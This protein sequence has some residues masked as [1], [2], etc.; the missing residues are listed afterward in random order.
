MLLPEKMCRILVVGSKDKLK[1]TTELLYSLE[2][3]HPIDYLEGDEG[4]VIGSPFEEASE[5]SERLLK[6]RAM[7]KDLEIDEATN[8]PKMP[9]SDVVKGLE[10]SVDGLQTQVAAVVETK[11]QLSSRN[12]ALEG[13]KVLLEPLTSIPL[14]LEL[15]SGYDNLTVFTGN[16]RSNPEAALNALGDIEVFRS[17]GGEFVAV[18]VAS[19]K[20]SEAQRIL[21]TN[22]F[23]ETALPQGKGSPADLIKRI[24]EEQANIAKQLDE[25]K[26]KLS[27]LKG[28]NLSLILASD[29]HLSIEV[30]KAEFPLRIATSK[31]AF[32]IDA[33]I[34]NKQ[35]EVVRSALHQ[36]LGESISFEIVEVKGRKEEH[37]EDTEHDHD[38]AEDT[39]PVKMTSRR[40]LARF[41]GFT[42]LISTPKYAE[43]DPTNVI[44]LTFPLFFGLMVGDVAYGLMFTVLGW[45]G[46]K[47]ARSDDWQ[48]ISTMLFFGGIWATFFGVFMFGEA[49]GLHFALRGSEMTWS[50]L[51]GIDFPHALNLGGVSIPLGVFSKLDDVNKLLLI[52]VWIGIFHLFLGFGLGMFNL[53]MRVGLKH[54]VMEKFGW[55]LILLGMALLLPVIIANIGNIMGTDFGSMA[56]LIP[57]VILLVGLAISLVGEGPLSIL[58]LPGLLSNILSYTRLTAIGTS[59][60][61][62][63]LAFNMIALQM[64]APAG[65]IGIVFG[66]LIFMV[67]HLTVFMLAIISAGIHGIRLHYV[68][69]FQKFYLGGGT[70]FNPL[71]IVRKHTSER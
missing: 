46:L 61:G 21:V 44:A 53:T 64:L 1:E 22:G 57:L 65:G 43:F 14:D 56:F 71:R 32:V 27:K 13:E 25:A 39:T 34:P 49:F 2:L 48:T 18:F 19:A 62:L 20:A 40:P 3:V 58:E 67:G 41:N 28:D 45:V 31:N 51:L 16:V 5:V 38:I 70:K 9:L 54:A 4:L 12:A 68:E 66:I 11:N 35:S 17:E 69:L 10:D 23:T 55:V 37:H 60:A 30:E 15:Y 59:K 6:L 52:S 33:W 29:E 50:S 8:A 63:A 42:E 26:D 47:K 7:E 24:G 36:K